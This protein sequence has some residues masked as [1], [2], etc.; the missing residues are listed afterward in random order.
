[1]KSTITL[2]T[3]LIFAVLNFYFSRQ[4]SK[5]ETEY[6]N[7]E[8]WKKIR[9]KAIQT[10]NIYYKVLLFIIAVLIGWFSFEK[11]SYPISLSICLISIFIVVITGQIIEIFAIKYY[12]K[13][14]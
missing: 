4:I 6:K 11:T 9:L 5:R 8:R 12:D 7:D 10:S 14:I 13:K 2:V 3:I 1:M